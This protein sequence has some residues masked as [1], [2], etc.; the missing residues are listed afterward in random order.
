MSHLTFEQLQAGLAGVRQS[1]ADGGTVELIV[2][3]PRMDERQLLD[4]G[5]LDLERGLVG[6]NWWQRPSR[7]MPDRSPHP[8]KQ[9]TVVNSRLAALVAVDPDRRA[10]AGDQL[11]VDLDL[12]EENLPAGTRLRL[13][14]AVIEVSELPHRGCDKFAHRF[15]IDALKFVNSPEAGKPFRLRGL[16]ARVVVPGAVRVGDRVHLLR[17]QE[18]EPPAA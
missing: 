11:H 18:E 14:E 8:G 16:N 17:A 13:G 6:D 1:P 4:R 15:G 2:A 3:R 12:S 10:L 7:D 9:I 5:V